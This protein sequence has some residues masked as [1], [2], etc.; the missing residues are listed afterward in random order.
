MGHWEQT[1]EAN[2]RYRARKA[3]QSKLRRRVE[4]CFWWLAIVIATAGYW[5]IIGIA[6]WKM[7]KDLPL[8]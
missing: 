4:Y 2:R 8:L 6:I 3:S 1:G 5:A 7:I